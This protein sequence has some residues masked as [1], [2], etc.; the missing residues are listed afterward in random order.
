MKPGE[1]TTVVNWLMT[2]FKMTN[3]QTGIPKSIIECY[4]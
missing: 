4:M 2:T 3:S 1:L